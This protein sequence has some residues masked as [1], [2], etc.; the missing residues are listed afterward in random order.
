M[1][2]GGPCLQE[3]TAA[4]RPGPVKYVPASAEPGPG[5]VLDGRFV[6]TDMI[7]RGGMATVFK[8]QDLENSDKTVAVKIP[9][10]NYESHIAYSARF[11]REEE[12]G[13]QLNHPYVLKFVPLTGRRSRPY[14]V[15]EYLRGCTLFDLLS[16]FR[17]FPEKDALA[18]AS[19]VCEAL[20]YLHENGVTHRDLKPENIMICHDGTIRLM[21]FGISRAAESRRIT[22]IG[23]APGTPHYMAPERVNCKR[24][25]ARTD[26]YSLGAMLY[27]MLTGTPPFHDDDPLVIM[28][29][30]VTGDPPAPRCLNSRLSPQTEEIV[31]H[32]MDR[33]PAQR[34]PT[35][36][37]MKAELD[38]PENIDVTGRCNRLQESTLWRRG[39]R[40]VRYVALWC[41]LPVLVQVIAF[42][43]LWH[44]L[45]RK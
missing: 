5:D 1:I 30:R 11:Q 12:I 35:A 2:L 16:T 43:L 14:L 21:D 20:Q 15:T 26:I 17:V 34:Y 23:F 45:S 19:L 44:H 41:L 25:D 29:A 39:M 9:H 37:A 4:D 3:R 8:A 27:E 32:A 22:F 6:L 38:T 13:S 40:K 33:D 10:W 7:S 36:A 28:N 31:L 24:G 18:I 42:L